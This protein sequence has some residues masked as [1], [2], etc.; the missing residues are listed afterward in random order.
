MKANPFAVA[1]NQ[2]QQERIKATES[3]PPLLPSAAQFAWMYFLRLNQTRHQGGFG[4]FFAIN[5]Q[6]MLAFFTLEGLFPEPYELE[7]IRVWDG[8]AL[9][10]LNKKKEDN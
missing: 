1:L 2:E 6:E 4:G 10:H 9:K 7:L 5:Y 3:E 8:V